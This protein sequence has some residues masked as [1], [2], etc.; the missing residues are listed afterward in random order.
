MVASCLVLIHVVC[1]SVS[2]FAI[3]S[4]SLPSGRS[5]SV[6]RFHLCGFMW[7]GRG[8]PRAFDPPLNSISWQL[9]EMT[10]V[11]QPAS[12]EHCS[13]D[14]GLDVPIGTFECLQNQC[15]LV[16]THGTSLL[17]IRSEQVPPHHSVFPGR[18]PLLRTSSTMTGQTGYKM[19]TEVGSFDLFFRPLHGFIKN[20]RVRERV[21]SQ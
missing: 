7:R 10:C 12:P 15:C 4:V 14:L 9:E 13:T 1:F 20:M 11:R 21:R 18:F 17:R 8:V 19:V 6:C 2:C 5:P 3:S 16:P